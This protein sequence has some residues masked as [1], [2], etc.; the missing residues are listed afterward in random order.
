MIRNTLRPPT[1]ASSTVNHLLALPCHSLS[2][3]LP[4]L[5]ILFLVLAC[6]PASTSAQPEVAT[7]F[8][9][10][11][12]ARD[13]EGRIV[14]VDLTPEQWAERLDDR[15]YYI[16]REHGTERPYSGRLLDE[17]R[18][19]IYACAGCGLALFDAG[20]KF[21]SRTG[22]PSFYEGIGADHVRETLDTSLGM[23][24]TETLCGRCNGHL[25]HVF[26]DGP[27]PTGLRYCI[28]SAALVFVP[29]EVTPAE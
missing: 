4:L 1:S 16:L 25:G 22:W 21:D 3:L 7:D 9:I 17:K 26:E 23:R 27:P 19:G 5:V 20:T 8:L 11:D 6:H 18:A 24:R 14:Q 13:A 10:K 28:N 12:P 15:Q 2:R 29:A